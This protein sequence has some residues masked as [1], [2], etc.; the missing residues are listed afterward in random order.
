MLCI[1]QGNAALAKPMGTLPLRRL[2]RALRHALQCAVQVIIPENKRN[3]AAYI[4]TFS[5]SCLP[6]M[7]NFFSYLLLHFL[8]GLSPFTNGALDSVPNCGMGS[9]QVVMG[10]HVSVWPLQLG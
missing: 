2:R 4:H 9:G 5:A 10:S 6:P 3:S 1:S 8:F 7:Y